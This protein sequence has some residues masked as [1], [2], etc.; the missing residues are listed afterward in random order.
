[1]AWCTKCDNNTQIV[2]QV[3]GHPVSMTTTSERYNRKGEYIGYEEG[4]AYATDISSTPLCSYC[5]SGFEFPNAT[6][7]QEYFDKKKA[8]VISRWNARRPANPESPG[9]GCV[10]YV[11]LYIVVIV[12]FVVG[13]NLVRNPI[14]QLI[15]QIA[16][17]AG[18]I[19][20][21]FHI[22]N[23]RKRRYGAEQKT[24][25]AETTAW[26]K[27]LD[28]LQSLAYTETSYRWLTKQ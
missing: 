5:G 15:V 17:I 18:A 12:V 14:G 20:L 13:L 7:R 6:S 11:G 9:L 27:G 24:Y 16:A 4:E 8:L 28:E 1:M 21:G 10:H 22:H 25:E 3:R 26:R 2:F 23:R 19:G